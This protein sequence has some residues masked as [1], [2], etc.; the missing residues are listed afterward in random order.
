MVC[1]FFGHE[2]L[3]LPLEFTVGGWC[4]CLYEGCGSLRRSV[5]ISKNEEGRLCLNMSACEDEDEGQNLMEE[6]TGYI[7]YLD[8]DG[9]PVLWTL[10]GLCFIL[11]SLLCGDHQSFRFYG[12]WG[13]S[14]HK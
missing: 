10:L 3:S 4:H 7:F 8:D 1:R 13:W 14:P 9:K 2:K 5:E 11:A 6:I 12:G